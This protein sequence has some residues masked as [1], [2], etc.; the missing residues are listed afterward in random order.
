MS[1][2]HLEAVLWDMDGVIADTAEYHYRAWKEIFGEKGVAFSKA[3]F[4]RYFG[5]RHDTIV[6]FAFGDKLSA[7]EAHTIAEKKQILY[8]RLVSANVIPLP[9]AVAL[10]RALNRHGIK[11]AIGTSAVPDNVTVILKG[12]RIEDC[13]QAIAYGME[14]PEGK[15]SPAI[16][17]LAARKLGIQP[18]NCVVI[19]DAIAGVDAARR[20]G[21]KCVAVTNSHPGD[22]L[23]EA[24]LV[25]DSLEKVNVKVLKG[26]FS[27]PGEK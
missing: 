18:A 26:L 20:A 13:F 14:V 8:R 16:F 1:N 9:G 25:V 19:E 12:L 2:P 24:D 15:P 3:D 17:L 11:T 21:M 23:Q 4:M 7:A 22:K 27:T 5:R 10:I 6:R